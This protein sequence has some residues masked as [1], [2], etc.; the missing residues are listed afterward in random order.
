MNKRSYSAI[1]GVILIL[2]GGLLLL[3]EWNVLDFTWDQTYPLFMLAI[4]VLSF[5][6]ASKGNK[7]AAFWGT[8]FLLTGLFYLLRNADLIMT[9]WFIDSWPI[10]LLSLGIG[11]FVLYAFK[12]HDWGVLIPA[13]VLTFLGII[14]TLESMDIP[15]ISVEA[16]L[17]LW[18]L[19]LILI[20]LGLIFASLARK[21]SETGQ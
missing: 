15:W 10:W 2:F 3:D 8:L 14:F 9:L 19:L 21:G 4:G 1:L 13:G 20:G 18:P 16:I 6:S 11:F 12:P 7:S 5:I 17:N